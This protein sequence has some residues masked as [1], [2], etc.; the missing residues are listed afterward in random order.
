MATSVSSALS[1]GESGIQST[2]VALFEDGIDAE[3]ALMALRKANQSAHQVSILVRSRQDERGASDD[4][5]DVAR[6]LMAAA[7]GAVANWL[8]GLAELIVPER[9]RYLVAGPMG[10]ALTGFVWSPQGPGETPPS[11]ILMTSDFSTDSLQGVL[12]DFGFSEKEAEYVEHRLTAGATLIAMTSSGASEIET[13]RQ[14][15]G[16][17]DAVY[18]GVAETDAAFLEAT[19]EVLMAGPELSGP[20]E[21]AVLDAIPLLRTVTEEAGPQD[22]VALRGLPVVCEGNV[23]AGEIDRV[24]VEDAGDAAPEE[25][26]DD[27]TPIPRYLIVA[28]GGVLGL[29]RHKVAVPLG[30]VDLAGRPIR[31]RMD[32]TTLHRAPAYDEDVPL[33]RREEDRL[34]RYFNLTPYWS[35]AIRAD[36]VPLVERGDDDGSDRERT[37]SGRG[38]AEGTPGALV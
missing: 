25:H 26:Q 8:I 13:V 5:V 30:L 14:V 37:G 20:G 15:F 21:A 29:G 6:D 24:I 9:G 1:A 12:T 2:V 11:S 27:S 36:P 34:F 19:R 31:V 35:D 23:E 17:H 4:P 16:D 10:A 22:L 28:F 18:I 3:R 7:L 38:D 33:S 32:K